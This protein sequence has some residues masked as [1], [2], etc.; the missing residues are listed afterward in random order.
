M[1]A[2]TFRTRGGHRHQIVRILTFVSS[3][4][5][6]TWWRWTEWLAKLQDF[7]GFQ[8]RHTCQSNKLQLRLEFRWK[9]KQDNKLNPPYRNTTCEETYLRTTSGRPRWQTLLSNN[10]VSSS[11]GNLTELVSITLQFLPSKFRIP[12]WF[13]LKQSYKNGASRACFTR[14]Q[15]RSHQLRRCKRSTWT[16]TWSSAATTRAKSERSS[17]PMLRLSYPSR[18]RCTTLAK[19]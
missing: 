11:N 12:T 7:P 4:L 2:V 5:L 1:Y 17:R 15:R 3:V 18:F 6:I 14:V 16:D 10:W 19:T 9:R 8:L 13:L